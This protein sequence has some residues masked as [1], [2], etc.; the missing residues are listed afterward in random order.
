[1]SPL[2]HEG[3]SSVEG[4]ITAC[5]ILDWPQCDIIGEDG[6]ADTGGIGRSLR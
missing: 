2:K 4:D 6:N 3:K 1:M 5:V